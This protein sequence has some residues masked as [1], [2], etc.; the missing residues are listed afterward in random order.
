MGSPGC[1]GEGWRRGEHGSIE[2]RGYFKPKVSIQ[3]SGSGSSNSAR[4]PGL[5]CA[6]GKLQ[7]MTLN[8]PGAPS[9]KK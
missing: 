1:P 2:V 3:A 4:F 9:R 7:D 6:E 8:K 5:L